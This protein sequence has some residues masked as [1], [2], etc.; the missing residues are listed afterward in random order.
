MLRKVLSVIMVL[1]IIVTIP[2][3]IPITAHAET[4]GKCGID[5]SWSLSDD[6]V[7][8]VKGTG[9]MT[10]YGPYAGT[11][12]PPWNDLKDSIKQV[13][14]D[15]DITSIGDYAFTNC[16]NLNNVFV[17][18][19][20]KSIGMLAFQECS[21][22][23]TIK[24]GNSLSYIGIQAFHNCCNLQDFVIPNSVDTIEHTA[25]EGCSS[26]ENLFIPS[27]V[28]SIRLCAF[29]R[30]NNIKRITVDPNNEVYDS[31]EDC[32]AI[33]SSRN[34]VLISGCQNTIVPDTVNSINAYAFY[35]CTNLK[36]IELP[37]SVS[38]IGISAFHACKNLERVN[39]PNSVTSIEV[40]TFYF[41]YSLKSII[42]PENVKIIKGSAFSECTDLQSVTLHK[43]VVTI[44]NCAFSASGNIRD[45]YYYGT[46]SMWNNIKIGTYNDDLLNANIHFLDANYTDVDRYV[47][48]QVKKYSSESLTDNIQYN[49]IMNSQTSEEVRLKM[50]NE[51]FVNKGFTDA[52]EG[53]DYLRDTSTY[54]DDYRFLTTD[55]IFCAT[56]YY[57]WLY[58]D[59]GFA[60]R[61]ALY[62]SGMIFNGELTAYFNPTTY[63]DRDF[64]GVKKNKK[65]LKDFLEQNEHSFEALKIAK[66]SAKYLSNLLKLNNIETNDSIEEIMNHVM[67]AANESDLD[68]YQKQFANYIIREA[69]ANGNNTI[70][71]EGER[72][73][74]ALKYG[75]SVIQFAN[76]TAN[77]IYEIMY[78]DQEIAKYEYYRDFLTDIY[79]CESVSGDMRM[80]AY[81]LLDDINNGYYNRIVGILGNVLKMGQDFITV[82][83]NIWKD[84]FGASGELF[85]DALA[86]IKLGVFI[87]N[88][89]VDTGD[90]VNQVSYTLGYGELSKVYCAKLKQ[91]KTAFLTAQTTENAWQFFSD[92]T[93]L[94]SLRYKGE[95]QYLKMN[96]V[97]MFI[98]GEVKTSDYTMKYDVANDNQRLLNQKK[99]E[100]AAN[101]TIPEGVMYSSK[102]VIN[103]PVDVY[104][105]N[106]A[107][108]LI[109]ELI[110][111]VESDV[112]NE[113]GRFAVMKQSY[114]GEY[115]KVIALN[116]PDSVV[117]KSVAHSQ[118]L[119]DYSI[120][121]VKNNEVTSYSLNNISVTDGSVITTSNNS[122]T[123]SLDYTGDETNVVEGQM[124][125]VGNEYVAVETIVS[126]ISKV[127]LQVGEKQLLSVSITP[128]NATNQ[129]VDWY[130]D[131][132]DI[133]SIKNGVVEALK[134]G[135]AT[136]YVKAIDTDDVILPFVINVIPQATFKGH[137]L[138]L[139]GDIGIN[140]YVDV[141]DEDVN[142][143]KVKVN[144]A[145]TVDGTENTHSVTLSANDKY[146]L[147]YKASCPVA[148]AE[149]TYDVTATVTIDG[150]VQ[151]VPDTY[152]AQKYAKAIL[153]NENNFMN[154][155]I[156]AENEKGR[157]GEQRYNN[158]IKLVQ[159]ML[160]YGTKA[161][162]T[163]N[164]DVNY[165]ANDGTDFFDDVAYSVSS[166]MISVT[167]E[168]MDMDLSAYGLRYKGS[169]VV[170]LSETSIRHYYY[171]DD[172]DSFNAIRNNVIFDGVAV[173]YTEKDG[174]IYFEKKGVS[175]SNL[176]TPYTLT[177]KDKSCKFAVND[178]IR[179]CLESDKVNDNTKALVRATY[180]Y[181]VAANAFFEV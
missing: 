60:A 27:S 151:S 62:S 181:N 13:I 64:P 19:S 180:R 119:V 68:S 110:D 92:Y 44:E 101:Y 24:L 85:G 109:A 31:R 159:T 178:Y 155:Y 18:D 142:N 154:K 103:C 80:A 34:N 42:I 118:G 168:N 174:A 161:Q 70:Y 17:S 29:S 37:D 39:I 52:K 54:R 120:A 105:Y 45:V 99:F 176:D 93:M 94:W 113:Y 71:L 53:I 134:P 14:I 15:A 46:E 25:F 100:F 112:T 137:S 145:W 158:L 139:N 8:S 35:G 43:S 69:Q 160:D 49:A 170:Y 124:I 114:S 58:S 6:G 144:F 111:G 172:W 152:S 82:D 162:I 123:Y 66:T 75:S 51:H 79:N 3:I 146:E 55:E 135:V 10:D 163:F 11:T 126:D 33:I 21:N 148:V 7:L 128:D 102:A 26:L 72:F 41:C 32:N 175:A 141:P 36:S 169:T 165:L 150:V 173:T 117:I 2:T 177:I 166:D 138:S 133:V 122:S 74:K 16:K 48:E 130:T 125:E 143:G 56:N 40:A 106:Q 20:V 153:N 88:I 84:L 86:T 67:S 91:D 164:R 78:L 149:M 121:A 9:K 57:D 157:N 83:Y 131:K 65:F 23:Q 98:F 108:D 4:N 12:V 61:A 38:S 156:T 96:R 171:V 73:S 76:A 47:I 132:E 179:H 22:L 1:V 104:V 95:D 140:F 81:L 89:V 90:F 59:S 147:G 30:C 116:N 63:T 5:A 97:K 87:S 77:D 129:T 28:K 50:L 167:E 136:V 107:G 115:A 127:D